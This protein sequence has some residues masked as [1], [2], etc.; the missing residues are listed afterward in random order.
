MNGRLLFAVCWKFLGVQ[1]KMTCYRYLILDLYAVL[2][3]VSLQC[4]CVARNGRNR[5]RLF[6]GART[7]AELYHLDRISA[8]RD[9]SA[10]LEFVPVIERPDPGWT[11]ETGLVTDAIARTMPTLRGYDAYVCGPPPMVAVAIEL[12]L[13]LG[14][15]EPNVYYDAFVPASEPFRPD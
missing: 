9:G 13:R 4:F 12:L 5:D 10:G 14:V 6:F 11:G 3:A 2:F 7:R 8:L 1:T 15:R